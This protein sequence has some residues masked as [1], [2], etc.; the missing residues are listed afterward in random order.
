VKPDA[1]VAHEE[2]FGPLAP[3]F[4]FGRG[5]GNRDVQQLAVWPRLYFYSRDLGRVWRVAEALI[6]MVASTPGDHDQVAP[7]GGVRR[8][9]RREGSHHGKEECRDQVRDDGGV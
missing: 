4:R 9:P 1:L 8:R 3:V 2:T 6:G 5:G 7:F